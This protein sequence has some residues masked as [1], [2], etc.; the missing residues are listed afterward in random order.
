MS[1]DC[2]R[3]FSSGRDLIT[4][5][6]NR[7]KCDLIEA[8]ELLRQWLGTPKRRLMKNKDDEEVRM[9]PFDG[10][11]DIEIDYLTHKEQEVLQG[12]ENSEK[13]PKAHTGQYGRTAAI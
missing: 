2:E 9:D 5:R 8:L 6:R 13:N 12:L 10:E 3:A 11:H 4:Y 1:D 7:L